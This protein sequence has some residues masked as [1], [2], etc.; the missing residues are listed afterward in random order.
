MPIVA[1]YPILYLVRFPAEFDGLSREALIRL[2]EERQRQC[3]RR[4]RDR[5]IE[6]R[7]FYVEHGRFPVEVDPS[8]AREQNRAASELAAPGERR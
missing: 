8:R 3:R 1:N 5:T 2:W 4:F 7:L 6:E